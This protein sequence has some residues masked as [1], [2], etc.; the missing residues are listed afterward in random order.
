MKLIINSILAVAAF[1]AV[2]GSVKAQ[3]YSAQ[4]IGNFT[5]YSNGVTAQR[6]GSF[7]YYSDGTTA[8]RVG[9]FTYFN[10]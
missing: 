5:Y 9:N 8:Q 7:T 10:K 4:R 1:A 6:V 3:S 2:A